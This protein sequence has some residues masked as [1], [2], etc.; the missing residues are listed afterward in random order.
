M[1]F[2]EEDKQAM[3]DAAIDAEN[4][5]NNYPDEVVLPMVEWWNKHF[6]KAGHKR[7]GRIL[8]G[9]AKEKGYGKDK[10]S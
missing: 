6:M 8:I 7:L 10:S 9:I 3:D 1:A 2:T 5:L 4:D